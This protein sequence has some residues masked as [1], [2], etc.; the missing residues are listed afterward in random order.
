MIFH[1]GR[2]LKFN[3][4][5]DIDN[6]RVVVGGRA[7]PKYFVVLKIN[8]HDQ[9]RMDGDEFRLVTNDQLF[10]NCLHFGGKH[11][12]GSLRSLDAEFLGTS[13]TA[14]KEWI[15]QT[16]VQKSPKVWTFYVVLSDNYHL[17]EDVRECRFVQG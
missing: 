16:K 15:W 7:L 12:P 17:S 9:R 14:A 5:N 11:S 13:W 1:E 2:R 6:S 8:I 10:V 4:S 3:L